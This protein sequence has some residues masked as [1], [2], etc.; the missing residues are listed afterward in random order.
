MTQVTALIVASAAAASIVNAV[1]CCCHGDWL[2]G[3]RDGRRTFMGLMRTHT[4]RRWANAVEAAA[5]RR[6]QPVRSSAGASHPR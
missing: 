2:Q 3:R 6:G 5:Q 4:P 1:A